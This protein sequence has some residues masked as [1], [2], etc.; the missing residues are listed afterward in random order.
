MANNIEEIISS[1]KD[2]AETVID[3]PYGPDNEIRLNSTFFHIEKSYFEILCPPKSWDIKQ[4]QIGLNCQLAIKHKGNTINIVAELDQVVTDRK[5]G[6]IAREPLK[7]EEM[8]EFFR[9]SINTPLELG[10]T[11]GPKEVKVTAWNMIGTTIDL[12]GCG[13]LGLFAE[14]PPSTNRLVIQIANPSNQDKIIC[15]GHVV[16]SYRMR[17]KRYQVAIHF[18]NIDQKTRDKVIACCLTEQRKQLRENIE[19]E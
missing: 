16:R 10:Y 7:P 13:V 11:P 17:K 18:D 19:L 6:F 3:M 5:L 4:L 15:V 12:S 9:V 8:R 2:G 1:I 14:K